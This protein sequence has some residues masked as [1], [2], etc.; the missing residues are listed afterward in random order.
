MANDLLTV[1]VDTSEA[2]RALDQ[3]VATVETRL[4][5][6]AMRAASAIVREAKAR[7]HRRTG[8]TAEGIVMTD[9]GVGAGVLVTVTR[10]ARDAKGRQWPFV[11]AWLEYG[12]E[13]EVASPFL[14]PSVRLAQGEFFRNAAT[15]LDDAAQASGLGE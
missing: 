3:F 7:V 10:E 1:T 15:I 14:G 5:E 13:H 2:V 6:N 9:Q 8:S 12:T 11:P 4:H